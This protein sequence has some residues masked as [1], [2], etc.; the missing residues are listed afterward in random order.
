MR[1]PTVTTGTASAISTGSS[2]ATRS[3]MSP[4]A[5]DERSGSCIICASRDPLPD[6]A[7]CCGPCR[8]R[9]SGQLRDIPI[10]CDEL[11]GEEPADFTKGEERIEEKADHLVDLDGE[12]AAVVRVEH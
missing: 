3:W 12:L 9:L 7:P 8:S 5:D 10:L 1:D 6:L 2:A 11:R 4:M